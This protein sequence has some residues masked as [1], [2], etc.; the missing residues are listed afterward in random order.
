SRPARAGMEITLLY[1]EVATL[2]PA[3][4]RDRTTTGGERGKDRIEPLDGGPIT[5]DHQAVAPFEPPHATGR[6][7]VEIVDAFRFQ[8]SGAPDVVLPERIAAVDD[9]IA[10]PKMIGKL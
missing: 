9:R 8:R 2:S 5:T 6:A 10:G 4:S 7:H 1:A 3:R